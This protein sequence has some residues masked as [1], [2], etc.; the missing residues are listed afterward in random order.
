MRECSADLRFGSFSNGGEA[1]LML[2]VSQGGFFLKSLKS[3]LEAH[4]LSLSAPSLRWAA[5]K[6]IARA[7][8]LKDCSRCSGRSAFCSSF[9]MRC[10]MLMPLSPQAPSA[11]QPKAECLAMG[12]IADGNIHFFIKPGQPGTSKEE[13]DEEVYGPLQEISGTISAEHGIGFEKRDWLTRTRSAEELAMMHSL[14]KTF[15]PREILNPQT[16]FRS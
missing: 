12:H 8:S 16:V 6:E 9:A 5:I 14:K 1:N 10:L 2:H 7:T 11:A 4:R 13:C 15:D 3:A